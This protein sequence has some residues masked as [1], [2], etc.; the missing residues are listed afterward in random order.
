MY[1]NIINFKSLLAKLKG[2]MYLDLLT[3]LT[4]FFEER[5]QWQSER[6]LH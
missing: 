3:K 4:H 5:F 2:G 6:S 1:N